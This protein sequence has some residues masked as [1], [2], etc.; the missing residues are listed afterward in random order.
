MRCAAWTSN[1]GRS[2]REVAKVSSGAAGDSGLVA[3][4]VWSWAWME[5]RGERGRENPSR[6]PKESR[7]I[8][9][10]E[11]FDCS[12]LPRASSP[13]TKTRTEAAGQH[14]AASERL[15]PPPFRRDESGLARNGWGV[16]PGTRRVPFFCSP[17]PEGPLF[18]FCPDKISPRRRT[19]HLKR[20]SPATPA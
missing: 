15:S 11:G 18:P 20:G 17:H 4:R 3:I 13:W 9:H 6:A 19:W 5:E 8:F 16:S 14:G 12:S 7:P 1:Q 10:C 2:T